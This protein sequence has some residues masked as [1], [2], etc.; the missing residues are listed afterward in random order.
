MMFITGVRLSDSQRRMGHVSGVQ[1][2]GNTVW[3]SPIKDFS[4]RDVW[5]YRSENHVPPN[6]VVEILHMSG[7]CLCGAFSKKNELDWLALFYP[8]VGG[9]IRLLEQRAHNA[10]VEEQSLGSPEQS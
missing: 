8:D 7:E 4:S 3:V 6:E 9:R 10:G 2:D 5:D 1:R